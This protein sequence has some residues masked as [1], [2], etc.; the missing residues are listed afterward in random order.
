MTD[1]AP[2]PIADCRLDLSELR[3]Q[4]ERYRAIGRYLEQIERHP[5]R[6]EVRFI[7]HLDAALLREAIELERG[8]CPF[9]EI[10][11]DPVEHRL[12]ITVDDPAQDPALDALQFAL[13]SS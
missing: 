3:A 9:F 6:L 8:C 7:P 1:P 12:S 2:L 11:H 10:R 13:T 5:R 4:R